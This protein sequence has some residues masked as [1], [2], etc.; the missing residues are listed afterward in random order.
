MAAFESSLWGESKG[1]LESIRKDNIDS[2][3]VDLWK[4]LE[5]Q[6]KRITIPKL[7]KTIKDPPKWNCKNCQ[8]LF[9]DWEII[10]KNCQEVGTLNWP[11]SKI[12]NP[13]SLENRTFF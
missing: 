4:K 3:V 1:F 8:S 6:S 11:K 7:P 12:T 13:K 5:N 10:C 9:E 2:R